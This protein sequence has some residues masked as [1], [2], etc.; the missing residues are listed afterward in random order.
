MTFHCHWMVLALGVGHDILSGR[1]EDLKVYQTLEQL[2]EPN[3]IEPHWGYQGCCNFLLS[4]LIQA[5]WYG[6]KW[7]EHV[8]VVVLP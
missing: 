6:G 8:W 1:E 4:E 7:R 3:L 5:T 2:R